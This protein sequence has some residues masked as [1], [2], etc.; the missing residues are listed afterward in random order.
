[1]KPAKLDLPTI[2]RGCDWGPVT[3]KWKDVDGN[4]I[5]LDG[6]QPKAESINIDLKP[7]ITSSSGGVTVMKLSH[8]DTANLRLGS[9]GWDWIW[10]KLDTQ[11]RYPPFLAGKVVI[12]EPLTS[13]N[14][15]QPIVPP[16][17]NDNFAD[18]QLIEGENGSVSGT[19]VGSTRELNE[20]PGDNSVWYKWLPDRDKQALMSIGMNWLTIESY[21]SPGGGIP[22]LRLI[23]T[24]SGN[25]SAIYWIA[26]RNTW[27]YIR[28]YKRTRTSAFNLIWSMRIPP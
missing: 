25:P 1:M 15:N 9:E 16:P 7:S 11:Y 23:A 19:N 8:V 27:Y 20:P 3:L 13:A 28:L 6:W 26:H 17:D 22:N 18:A 14:G 4:P 21:I 12:K 2:W 24:S 10:E 5:N